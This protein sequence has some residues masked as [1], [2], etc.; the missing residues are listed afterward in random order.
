[1]QRGGRGLARP[2]I[3]VG[4]VALLG[5]RLATGAPKDRRERKVPERN[6]LRETESEQG[7]VE[8]PE[9]VI[10]AMPLPSGPGQT[11][12]AVEVLGTQEMAVSR[13]ASVPEQLE[14]DTTVEV[15]ERGSGSVQS[16]LSIR[17]STFQQVLVTLDGL[18]LTD[19]QTAH[20]NMDVPF[21]LSALEKITV[22][23]GPGTALFGPMAF[24][25][26]VDLEP[27]RP[28]ESGV[29]LESAYGTFDTWRAGATAD[30]VVGGRA[31]TVAVRR[32]RSNGFQAGTDYET[33]S[34]WG[35]TYFDI[36][37]GSVRFSAGHADKDFGA[38]DF[39]LA[40]P[41]RERTKST[42]VDLAP[43][44]E[45]APDWRVKAIFRYRRHE[46]EFLL[47]EDDPSFYRNTHVSD[48]FIERVTVTAPVQA[49][50]KTA[51][52]LERSDAKL[53]SSSLGTREAATTSTFLQHRLFGKAYTA[54][55]G[56]RLDDHGDW[57][58]EVSPSL[59]LS[60]PLGEALS[61]HGSAARGLRPP[62]F[63]E[64]YYTDPANT[65]DP[66]LDPE[67]AWGGETGL[68]FTLPGGTRGVLTY[69]IRDTKRLIDWVRRSEEDP[70]QATN[71][72]EAT[73]RGGEAR[74]G[75][76]SGNLS[77]EAAYRYTDVDADDTGLE[78]KY[79]L[80]V[81]RHDVRMTLGLPESRGFA[82]SV[83]ARYR[84]V[85]TLDD[86]WLVSARLAQRIGS[87][88]VF[89]KGRNLLDEDYEEIPGVPTA[90]R[91]I[92]A[93]LEVVF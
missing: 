32:E 85:S 42:V 1:M 13:S 92:E 24:A 70:W 80:N 26:V 33:W 36:E 87:V 46:D 79:A 88:V 17:G 56:L 14:T 34:A 10:R 30:G 72:G 12:R 49:F 53:D 89:A 11:G 47:I 82:A 43:R 64:L 71:T 18:P 5:T 25:G 39:Y 81:A 69:F 73:F 6:V 75:A 68:D 4:V 8:F 27:R 16:D 60:V 67:E 37:G 55:L 86:Y 35:S 21:P 65:G 61:W 15:S 76:T 66:G 9:I 41:S 58:T 23:P 62:S 77:W 45:I 50:G 38:Q 22:I 93:G 20:H 44:F 51:F 84:D 52:G 3:L 48:T 91:Y 28:S 31:A 83:T 2:M 63:T 54:D 7:V 74:M 57:G 19:P 29:R 90:G 59:S 40:Y 78:S